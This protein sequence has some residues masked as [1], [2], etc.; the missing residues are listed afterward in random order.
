MISQSNTLTITPQ[1]TSW[2]NLRIYRLSSYI[3][4]FQSVCMFVYIYVFMHAYF[5]AC[6]YVCSYFCVYVC[7]CVCVY[8]F[9]C[10]CRCVCMYLLTNPSTRAGCDTRSM[11]KWSLTGLNSEFSFSLTGCLIKAKEPDLPHYLPLVGG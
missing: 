5:C 9:L 1:W 10:I 2:W 3:P 7:T 8:V 4:F 6:V 11:F